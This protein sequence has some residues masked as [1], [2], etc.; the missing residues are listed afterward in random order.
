M[1][2]TSLFAR[3]PSL[4]RKLLKDVGGGLHAEA[5]V[6]VDSAGVALGTG[7][8]LD[9]V[10]LGVQTGTATTTSGATTLVTPPAGTIAQTVY[11]S[12]AVDVYINVTLEA[13]T[14]AGGFIGKPLAAGGT[15]DIPCGQTLV[16]ITGSSTA[17]LA[18][19]AWGAA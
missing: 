1:A 5:V 4:I 17:V 16:A 7:S 6:P 19:T 2:D 8:S 18:V 15:V 3:F 12:G 13:T 9:L 10:C 14:A 11:N